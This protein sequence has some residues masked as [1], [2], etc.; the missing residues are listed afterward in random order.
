[1]PKENIDHVFEQN[2]K[3]NTSAD[4]FDSYLHNGSEMKTSVKTI[5]PYFYQNLFE[6]KT[7]NLKP[8]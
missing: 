2:T 3:E 4:L 5:K 1:M 6:T 8:Q 7:T